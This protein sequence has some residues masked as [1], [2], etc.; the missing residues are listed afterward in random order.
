[1][2]QVSSGKKGVTGYC[3]GGNCALRIAALFGSKIGAAA[4]IHGGGLASEQPD[5]PH[6]GAPQIEAAVYAAF[7]LTDRSCPDA[8]RVRLEG[9]LTAAKVKHTFEV[10]PGAIHGFA[11]PDAPSFNAEAAERHYAALASHFKKLTPS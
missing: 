11:V 1:M 4:S 8:M 2:P 9:A 3:L 10:Y 6:L 7:A 5:S